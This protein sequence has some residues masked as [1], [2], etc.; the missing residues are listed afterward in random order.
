MDPAQVVDVQMAAEQR[1]F[2]ADDA[3]GHRSALHL[4]HD[5]LAG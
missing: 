1:D 3:A 5:Y 4:P 2:D